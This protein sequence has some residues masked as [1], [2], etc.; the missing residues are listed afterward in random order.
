MKWIAW[1]LIALA[2]AGCGRNS[3]APASGESPAAETDKL[4]PQERHYVDAARPFA[5]A[6]A[7]RNYADAYRLLSPRAT[8]RM[9]L[10]QFVPGEDDAVFQRNEDTPM[11]NV[12]AEQFAGLMR[13]VEELHGAPRRLSHID[14]FSTDAD[15]LARKSK[16]Q[17]GAL[18]SMFAI[19]A[20]PDTIP[21]EIRRA[22]LR[23]QIETELSPEQ[24]AQAAKE[25]GVTAEELTKEA[26]YRPYFNVKIVLVE[27]AGQLRVGYFEFLPPSMMD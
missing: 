5:E 3:E 22:S 7:A 10:N 25:M 18:D 19:G 20:M 1:L 2:V 26:D 15:V 8:A 9:S 23:G 24:L 17:L 14:V 11:A 12:S 13:R 16:D 6:I 21:A 4:S 27:E